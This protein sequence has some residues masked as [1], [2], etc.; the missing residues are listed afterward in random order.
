MRQGGSA[1]FGKETW[2]VAGLWIGLGGL[3]VTM[4]IFGDLAGRPSGRG[5]VAAE[6]VRSSLSPR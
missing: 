5:G 2:W 6:R 3:C 4:R 1:A